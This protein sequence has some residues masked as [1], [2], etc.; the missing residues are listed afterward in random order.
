MKIHSKYRSDTLRIGRTSIPGL[1]YH[2]IIVTN[3]RK[4]VLANHN[5]AT[6]IFRA[7]DWLE[8]E[9]RLEW[10]CIMV[11]PDHVHTVIRLAE[12]QT[13]QKVLHSLKRFTAREVNKCLLREG[14][15]WQ[16]GYSDW[17]IRSEKALNNTIRYCY[18]NPVRED[19]VKSAK[20]Y[21]Y[22]RCKF[23]ME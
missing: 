9:N 10:I 16:K 3:Q 13:L 2:I 14:S 15:L 17:G 19:I 4:P 7:F 23:E 6:I 11:M 12:G 1:Y 20:D 18:M 22:W 5:A 21:R 8:I